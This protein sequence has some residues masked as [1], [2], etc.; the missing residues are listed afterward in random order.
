MALVRFVGAGLAT[1]AVGSGAQVPAG[2]IAGGYDLIAHLLRTENALV[3]G[4]VQR[5]AGDIWTEWKRSGLPTSVAALHLESLPQ[6]MEEFRPSD[7]LLVGSFAVVK[8]SMMAGRAGAVV[9]ARKLAS[10]TISQA[11]DAHK[12]KRGGLSETIAFFFIERI[13]V[14]LLNERDAILK[15][16][17]TVE[18]YFS[19]QPMPAAD[20]EADVAP[21]EADTAAEFAPV[22]ADELIASDAELAAAPQLAAGS[23]DDTW[24]DVEATDEPDA[25]ATAEDSPLADADNDVTALELAVARVHADTGVPLDALRLLHARLAEQFGADAVDAEVLL[26]QGREYARLI[27]RLE[28]LAGRI[29]EAAECTSVAVEALGL[30]D[31]ETADLALG[32]AEDIELEAARA[33][34][35]T[36]RVRL[37]AA[38]DL[39]AARAELG[40]ACGDF[41]AAASHFAVAVKTLPSVERLA[42]WT[43]LMRQAKM[44]LQLADVSDDPAVLAEAVQV[45][46]EAVTVITQRDAPMEWAGA[47]LQIAKLLIDLAD[48]DGGAARVREALAHLDLALDVF[49]RLRATEDWAEVQVQR[50]IALMR[51]GESLNDVALLQQSVTTLRSALGALSADRAPLASR[52][53]QVRLGIALFVLGRQSGEHGYMADALTQLRSVLD[54]EGELPEGLDVTT[55]D[56]AALMVEVSEAICA[57]RHDFEPHSATTAALARFVERARAFADPEDLAELEDRLSNCRAALAKDRNDADMMGE[58]TKNKLA[59]ITLLDGIAEAKRIAKLK[60]DLEQMHDDMAKLVEARTRATHGMARSA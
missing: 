57:E 20:D 4:L 60:A 40:S 13:F 9:P 38:A 24:P 49:A 17:P 25:A 26:Q 10:S 45:Y 7:D 39:R 30:G 58:A 44:L 54:S 52:E 43:L 3:S 59:A 53:A 33:D 22:D 2:A 5:A 12:F 23:T 28:P 37:A 55:F 42:C 31:L 56:V 6:L 27:R 18:A 21:A 16:S 32:Q 19:E 50:G 8:S 47:H 48:H 15:L 36:A 11:R 1:I 14:H 34:A 51:L 46:R 29:G 41:R 35:A